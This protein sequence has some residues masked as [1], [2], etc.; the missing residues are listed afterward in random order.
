MIISQLSIDYNKINMIYKVSKIKL[1]LIM[2][3]T[4]WLD[5][6][7]G[8]VAIA[9]LVSGLILLFKGISSMPK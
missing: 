9:I 4:G 2:E 8:G 7:I 3:N 6:L 1:S 5:L